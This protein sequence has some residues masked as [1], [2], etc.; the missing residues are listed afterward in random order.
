[1]EGATEAISDVLTITPIPH[2]LVLLREGK[3]GKRVGSEVEPR[4]KGGMGEGGFRFVLIS[5]Y[6][7]LVLICSKLNNFPNSSLF[8]QGFLTVKHAE[9]TQILESMSG[10]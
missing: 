9:V 3:G 6:H 2:P 8:S 5:H 7:T 10:V 4:K 1:M